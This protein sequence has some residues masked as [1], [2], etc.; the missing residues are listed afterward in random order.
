MDIVLPVVSG[1]GTSREALKEQQVAILRAAHALEAA[2]AEATP[3]GRDY[4]GERDRWVAA[5]DQHQQRVE[6]VQRIVREANAIAI[7]LR[8]P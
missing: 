2:L 1:N 3:N 7:G 8:K 6:A 5:L 4:I